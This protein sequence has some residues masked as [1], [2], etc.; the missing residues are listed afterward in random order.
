VTN[1]SAPQQ[2][3]MSNRKKW[4]IGGALGGAASV[5]TILTL[6]ITAG[7]TSSTSSNSSNSNNSSSS[8]S[9]GG[10]SAPLVAYPVNAQ[11][12]FLNSCE[13]NSTPAACQCL[14]SWLEQNVQ[15][16]QFV[17]D[18]QEASEGIVPEDLTRAEQACG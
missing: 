5:A 10:A 15:F 7:G 17:V 13:V 18:N 1:Q 6:F 2:P 11:T 12:N 8:T 4:S 3:G 16:Q 9:S 14:L